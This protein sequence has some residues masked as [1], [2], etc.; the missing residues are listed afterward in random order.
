MLALLL[1]VITLVSVLIIS[2]PDGPSTK[3]L[4]ARVVACKMTMLYVV[5][6]SMSTRDMIDQGVGTHDESVFFVALLKLRC[7]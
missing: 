7:G 1:T 6:Y 4:V 3:A 2:F 5:P